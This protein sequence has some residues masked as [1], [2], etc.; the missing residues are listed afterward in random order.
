MALIPQR[1]EAADDDDTRI[2]GPFTHHDLDFLPPSPG[3]GPFY[4][5]LTHASQHG[6]ALI[7]R[8]V[9]HAI[10]FY[11]DGREYGAD[12]FILSFP[13]GERAF[14]WTRSYGWSRDSARHNSLT[15]ALMALEAWAHRRIEAGESIELVLADVL[16]PPGTPAAFLLV[17]VDL[18]LSHW[19]KSREAAIPF[20]ACAELLCMDRERQIL[21]HVSDFDPFGLKVQTKE[22]VGVPRLEE[23]KSRSSRRSSLEELLGKYGLFESAELR[24]RLAA[25]LHHAAQRLGQPDTHANFRD[26]AFM[27]THAL[28]RLEPNNW[29]EVSIQLPDGRQTTAHEYVPPESERKHLEALQ[30]GT[31]DRLEDVNMQAGVMLALENPSRSSIQFA[32]AAVEWARRLMTTSK[33][34]ETHK[35]G[36]D[37]QGDDWIQEHAA[38]SAA[39][40][41]MRDGD[42]ELRTKH[43]AWAHG[44]F[45]QALRAKD[46]PVLRFRSG[47]RYNPVAV[48]FVGMVHALKDRATTDGIR[49]L[50]EVATREEPTAAYG[51]GVAGTTL[52]AIDERLLRAVLRCAFTA[53]IRTHR[54]RGRSDE[55]GPS[56]VDRQRKRLLKAVEAELAWL[57]NQCPEPNWPIF[58]VE[59]PRLRRHIRFRDGRVEGDEPT[60]RRSRPEQYADHQAAAV[61]LTNCHDILDMAKRPWFREMVRSYT[62]WTAQANGAGLDVSEDV[63]NPPH[64]WNEAYFALLARC[65]PGLPMSEIEQVALKPISS[66]PDRSFFDVLPRFLRSSDVVYFND[67]ALEESIAVSIRSK[68]AERLMASRG[69]ERLRGQRGS[70]IETHI[71]PAI[72]VLFFNDYGY[73]QPVKCYLSS[74][75]IDR[76][77]PFFPVLEKLVESGSSLFVALVTLNLLEVSPRSTHLP[78]LVKA[79]KV[80][81]SIYPGDSEFWVAHGIGR[82]VCVLIEKI[83]KLEPAVLNT[84]GTIRLDLDRVLATLV[85]LGVPEARRLEQAL[86]M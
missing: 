4:E 58:P 24:V 29:R 43:G 48:A 69:W 77:A 22:A 63:E 70:S 47:L 16:G 41:V 68:V 46:D 6:L 36:E 10:S 40:I 62:S 12:A 11:T 64:E 18:M 83:Q 76:L 84:A 1:D 50:L 27:V 65:L 8:L 49:S 52:A 26:P 34:N 5:L 45:A 15:S 79:A 67:Q 57:S 53:C 78:F 20:V 13:D 71:G 86:N 81:L 80:W 85:S 30:D 35:H 32:T 21:E 61:W 7:R 38:V 33:N 82:R 2:R 54:E 66:F 37:D 75:C 72:A 51:F 60:R 9:D 39:T 23:L 74:A 3:Q 42:T 55:G 14:P 17:A 44:V 59:A 31:K 28:N 56:Y 19:P 25:L 73:T